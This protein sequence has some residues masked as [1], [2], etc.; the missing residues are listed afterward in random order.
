MSRCFVEGSWTGSEVQDEWSPWQTL[1]WGEKLFVGELL[2]KYNKTKISLIFF[3]RKIS[4]NFIISI[5]LHF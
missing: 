4:L 5:Y 1:E 3:D 2:K